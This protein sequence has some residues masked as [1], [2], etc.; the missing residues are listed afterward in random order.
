MVRGDEERVRVH[1]KRQTVRQRRQAGMRLKSLDP[2]ASR[3]KAD[4]GRSCMRVSDK[5]TIDV[6]H[7]VILLRLDTFRGWSREDKSGHVVYVFMF[8]GD[9]DGRLV[10]GDSSSAVLGF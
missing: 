7:K 9:G 3:V 10:K 4:G 5:T 6:R 2:A 1:A 8:F